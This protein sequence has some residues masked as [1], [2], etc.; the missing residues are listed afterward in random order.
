M[1]EGIDVEELLRKVRAHHDKRDPSFTIPVVTLTFSYGPEAESAQ[2]PF[3]LP[4]S[5]RPEA[6]PPLVD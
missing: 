1:T 6:D 5:I 2:L 4:E 3:S